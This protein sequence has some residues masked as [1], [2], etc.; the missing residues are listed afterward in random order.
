MEEK[1]GLFSFLH[2]DSIVKNLTGLVEKRVELFKIE[3]KEDAAKAGAKVIV[4]LISLISSFMAILFISF[5]LGF[6][7]GE[8]L[9]NTMAG[10]LLIGGFYVLILFI[11]IGLNK[12]LN[13]DSK[14][15]KVILD[16]LDTDEDGD[17]G[18]DDSK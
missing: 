11:F 9:N 1:K 4:L 2:V 6:A 14:L 13:I 3:F 5:G 15:E 18:E 7:L 16:I 8:W 17:E 12:P 10:F